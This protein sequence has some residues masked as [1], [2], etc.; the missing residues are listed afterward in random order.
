PFNAVVLTKNADV[1][2]IVTPIGAAANAKAA[3]V[4]IADLGSLE[5][6]ADVSETNI[7]VVK[8]GQPCEIQ[9]DA[10]PG[11]R[12]RG[13]VHMIVPTADR[14]K[15]TVLVKVRF[16]DKDPRI[17]PEMR[18]KVS[19]LSRAVRTEEQK[20]RTEVSKAAVVEGGGGSSVFVINGNHAVERAVKTGQRFND[21]IEILEG[22][23]PG[24][25][26][27]VRPPR[28]LKNGARVKILEK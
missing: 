22:V 10:F 11:S 7:G 2:D 13:A 23:E 12:F 16:V 17:L 1:G 19:F 8:A 6:E 15:A 3:V 20:P 9:L 24:Q 18:A 26:V 28:G 27:V 14:S 4:T 5:V 25:R 21:Q